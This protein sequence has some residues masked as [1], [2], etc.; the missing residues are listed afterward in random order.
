MMDRHGMHGTACELLGVFPVKLD[1][2]IVCH[3]ENLQIHII[4]N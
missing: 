1:L 3:G 2:Q 4:T